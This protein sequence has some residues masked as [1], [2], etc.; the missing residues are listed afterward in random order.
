MPHYKTLVTIQM[1][2]HLPND[3]VVNT[4]HSECIG[5]PNDFD[6]FLTALEQFYDDIASNLSSAV[7]G[8]G[9]TAKTYLMNDPEP[10]APVDV[11]TFGT[12]VAGATAMP[13]ELALVLSFQGD[14]VSGTPQARRRG[15]VYIG[16]LKNM[17]VSSTDPRVT[18]Q[19]L[20][21]LTDAAAALMAAS[22]A[23]AN[24]TWVVYSQADDAMVPVTNGWVDDA[25]DIQRRRG[26][27]PSQRVLFP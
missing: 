22:D 6:G 1:D 24:W 12:M 7:D 3:A 21:D 23:A 9:F 27:L 14:Q 26:L 4:W 17:P 19:P 2:S 15:R 25:F 20:I 11:R 5:V 8:T 13:P 18:G 10:R 16:P